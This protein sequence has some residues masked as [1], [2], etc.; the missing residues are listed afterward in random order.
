MFWL[1]LIGAAVG[2][3]FTLLVIFLNYKV[4]DREWWEEYERKV[5]ATQSCLRKKVAENAQL[6][7]VLA[8]GEA[9]EDA[10]KVAAMIMA[11]FEADITTADE[12]GEQGGCAQSNHCS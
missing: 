10:K 2:V 1:F 5:M 4:Q 9:T 6:R 12:S 11:A 3:G 7:V 8:A